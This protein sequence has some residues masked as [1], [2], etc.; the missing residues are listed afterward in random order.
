MKNCQEFYPVLAQVRI[1]AQHVF[2]PKLF[3]PRIWQICGHTSS[4]V[5]SCI[6]A[7][8]NTCPSCIVPK[9]FFW[10]VL[11][12]ARGR[13]WALYFCWGIKSLL[14][15]ALQGWVNLG[16]SR[17]IHAW[18]PQ[19]CACQRE[20]LFPA[21]HAATTTL[22]S[23]KHHASGNPQQPSR[24]TAF[25]VWDGLHLRQAGEQTSAWSSKTLAISNL[26]G[27]GGL[28]V[29]DVRVA[30]PPHNCNFSACIARDKAYTLNT[31]PDVHLDVHLDVHGMSKLALSTASC[32][33]LKC[34]VAKGT[35]R[36]LLRIRGSTLQASKMHYRV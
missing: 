25:L 22:K 32:V 13:F 6:R 28:R 10:R 16:F 2:A 30:G 8:A 15:P 29:M 1:Q 14:L 12:C 11:V 23:P 20:M 4:K 7:S 36:F 31:C 5:C 33:F 19:G 3:P 26:G 35:C 27:G 17:S 34:L 24:N 9:I 18:T 21:R